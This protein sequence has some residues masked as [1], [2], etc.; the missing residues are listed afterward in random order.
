MNLSDFCFHDSVL[1]NAFYNWKNNEL[2]FELSIFLDRKKRAV[3]FRIK[4]MEIRK[5]SLTHENPWGKS[6]TLNK[7]V[8]TF[9][10]KISIEIQ[11]GDSIELEFGSVQIEE[12]EE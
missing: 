8:E 7:I 12:L 6:N 11:S 5:L 3:P 1:F 10:G 9:P 2:T 4:F